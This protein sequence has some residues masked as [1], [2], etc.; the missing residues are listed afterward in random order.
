MVGEVNSGMLLGIHG[1]VVSIQADIGDGLPLFHMIGSLSAEVREAK[2]RVKTAMKNSG[3]SLPAKRIAVNIAPAD[4]RKCGGFFDAA[5]AVSLLV[6]LKKIPS[7]AVKN[8]VILGE[9]SLDGHLL[10][11]RGILPIVMAARKKGITRCIV[12]KENEKEAALV[13]ET[14]VYAFSTLSELGAFLGGKDRSPY[15]LDRS[16]LLHRKK[17]AIT[18]V[19]FSEIKGQPFAKRGAEIAAA[20]FHNLLL[21]GPPGTGKSMLASAL[22][23]ILPKMDWQEMLDLT[24]IQSAR[25]VL[26]EDE[27]LS[28]IRPY[29]AP[30]MG[31]TKAGLFGGGKNPKPGEVS[32]AHHGI[33]FL[34]EITEMNKDMIETLRIPLERHE[35]RL[36]RQDHQVVFPAD[37]ILVAACNPCFCGFFPD[38]QRCRCNEASILRYQNKLSGP[39]RDRIDLF[40]HCDV[41]KYSQLTSSK[42]EE[43]SLE[44]R[45]R[46][47]KSWEFRKARQGEVQNGRLNQKQIKKYC[48]LDRQ[49]NAFMEKAF[50]VFQLSGRSYYK[51]IKVARTIADL[52][53]EE[54]ILQRHLEEAMQFRT[55]S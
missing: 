35:V 49:G 36:V 19:D 47:Q 1:F 48:R 10:P 25:G 16:R 37:F 22:P 23:G 20:G 39:I 15:R 29:R 4:I 42:E 33:L 3:F 11:L 26:L 52:E 2:E 40:V 32:L 54:I 51:V 21:K 28:E 50:Q 14:E 5:I 18:S 38:R 45:K 30:S 43:S 6:S 53:E 41:P 44:V 34:D 9:L 7:S 27:L 46:V 17:N 24:V 31:V 55:S 8:I 12:P 13:E